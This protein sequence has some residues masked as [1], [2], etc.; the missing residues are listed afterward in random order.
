MNLFEFKRISFQLETRKLWRNRW[1]TFHITRKTTG[2]FT[3]QSHYSDVYNDRDQL[4]EII[5]LPSTTFIGQALQTSCSSPQSSL[6]QK[7]KNL[8]QEKPWKKAWT[9][10]KHVM[11]VDTCRIRELKYS[12]NKNRFC[13]SFTMLSNK[14]RITMQSLA[15]KLRSGSRMFVWPCVW[16]VRT[17]L[18]SPT[19]ATIAE[20]VAR[21]AGISICLN[22]FCLSNFV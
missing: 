21:Y 10:A 3:M 7:W 18:P 5:G 11:N 16:C 4:S 1:K 17:I 12:S 13:S 20:H 6:Q 19:D 22:N 15:P 9:W 8:T 14:M 2:T